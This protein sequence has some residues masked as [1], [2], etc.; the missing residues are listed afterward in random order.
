MT[1]IVLRF[2]AVSGPSMA[3]RR[4]CCVRS[5][6][7]RWKRLGCAHQLRGRIHDKGSLEW[8]L[9]STRPSVEIPLGVSDEAFRSEANPGDLSRIS[10]PSISSS[11]GCVIIPLIG[12]IT[13]AKD[14]T[15][16]WPGF[17]PGKPLAHDGSVVSLFKPGQKVFPGSPRDDHICLVAFRIDE[18]S[19]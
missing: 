6:S 12:D 13:P 17:Q 15:L 9:C 5:P 2:I 11:Y 14:A 4:F 18:G 7:I 16:V 8:Q 19:H 3:A 10:G 1:V